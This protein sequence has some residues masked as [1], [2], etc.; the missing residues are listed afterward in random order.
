MQFEQAWG[1]VKPWEGGYVNDPSDPG[2]ETNMGISKKA[3]PAEDIKN[4]TPERAAYLMKATYW[5][6][7]FCNTLPS[8][9]DLYV[10]DMGINMGAEIAARALQNA[11][12]KAY[13]TA[14]KLPPISSD[15]VIGP[16][17]LAALK[18]IDAVSVLIE[19]DGMRAY[20]Y[21]TYKGFDKY[22]YGWERRAAYMLAY[23]VLATV[24]APAINTVQDRTGVLKNELI[25]FITSWQ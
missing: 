13:M 14:G 23:G 21:G 16:K 25:H 7:N 3:F 8:G 24:Q 10:L 12:I 11:I 6:P 22:G 20:T 18:N 9:I 4:L 17:T 19:L 5:T 15:G 2:G 1:M